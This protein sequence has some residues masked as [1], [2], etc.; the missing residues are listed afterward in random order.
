MD[1]ECG[2]C[3]FN[4]YGSYYGDISVHL[5]NTQTGSTDSENEAGLIRTGLSQK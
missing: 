5:Q 4:H 3:L 2:D 1:L